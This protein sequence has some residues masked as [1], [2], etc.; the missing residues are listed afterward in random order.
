M[1]F[2]VWLPFTRLFQKSQLISAVDGSWLVWSGFHGS[3]FHIV[4]TKE[5][6]IPSRRP[7]EAVLFLVMVNVSATCITLPFS[8]LKKSLERYLMRKVTQVYAVN[9]HHLM[10][11]RREV[12][13]INDVIITNAFSI[14][15]VM[16]EDSILL[17]YRSR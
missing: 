14:S 17:R 2:R 12:A 4:L 13:F 8:R 7:I 15:R 3:V 10:M 11:C 1:H 5:R 16:S 6:W 9:I